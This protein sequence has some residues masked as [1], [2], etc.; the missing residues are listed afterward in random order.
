MHESMNKVAQVT[1]VFWVMKICA[2]T[3]GETGGDLLSMTLSLGYAVST[4]VFFGIFLVTLIAQVTSRSYHPLMYWAVIISTTTAGTT[5]SDY[6]D[7]TAGLGYIGGSLLLV[8]ILIS[9][10][11]IW[12]LALG[13]VSVNKIDN[14]KAEIFYWVTIIFYNTL[15]TALGDFLADPSGLGLG[16]EGGALVI[17]AV[18]AIIA[19]AYF[20]TSVLLTPLFWL[21]FILTR[22]LG[23]TLGDILTKTH[24]QGGLD[25]GTIGSSIVLGIFLIVC[26]FFVNRNHSRGKAQQISGSGALRV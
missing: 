8:A 18:L 11:G 25:L 16:Y 3:L 24:E 22:P 6:L 15:G 1:L 26:V 14:P 19:A 12:R 9:V 21:A 4:A 5:M 20:L 2:T 7:R 13:S 10:L 17:F 23:A